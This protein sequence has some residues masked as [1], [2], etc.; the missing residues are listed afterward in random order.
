MSKFIRTFAIMNIDE[1]ILG[2]LYGLIGGTPSSLESQAKD[3]FQVIFKK[4][5][6]SLRVLS[7]DRVITDEYMRGSWIGSMTLII[8]HDG[9]EYQHTRNFGEEYDIDVKHPDFITD[10][11]FYEDEKCESYKRYAIEME[12]INKLL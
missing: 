6:E 11:W 10:L 1:F 7:T 5:P 9:V 3:D 12:K 2:R 8:K 4:Q